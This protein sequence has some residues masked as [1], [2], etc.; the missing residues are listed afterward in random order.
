M[1]I[2][3]FQFKVNFLFLKKKTKHVGSCR[4]PV[5]CHGIGVAEAASS[6]LGHQL[7]FGGHHR[8]ETTGQRRNFRQHRPLLLSFSEVFPWRCCWPEEC[9]LQRGL[10]HQKLA[11]SKHGRV[12][13][14]R[15]TSCCQLGGGPFFLVA[16]C[17]IQL[18]TWRGAEGR[19]T[20]P[21]SLAEMRT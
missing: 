7:R 17:P 10:L 5:L 21:L 13:P 14:D 18:V 12:I 11:Q 9:F 15:P 2:F 16:G 4:I 6:P 20:F 8:S 3:F 19:G 1:F